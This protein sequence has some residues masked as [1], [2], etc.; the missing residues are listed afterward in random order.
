M[1][2]CFLQ[3][4]I[5]RPGGKQTLTLAGRRP[6]T[7]MHAYNGITVESTMRPMRA[8]AGVRTSSNL[9]GTEFGMVGREGA[10]IRTRGISEV[11]PAAC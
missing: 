11:S 1:R 8:F 4:P 9:V 10:T 2:L 3:A 5:A 6:D 7:I